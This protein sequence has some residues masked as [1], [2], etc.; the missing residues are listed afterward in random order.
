MRLLL[1]VALVASTL[2]LLTADK[3]DARI[4]GLPGIHE[5]EPVK[6]LVRKT[7]E[8]VGRGK[9][10]VAEKRQ[11]QCSAVKVEEYKNKKE[12]GKVFGCKILNGTEK[13][14]GGTTKV[15]KKGYE[16][17]YGDQDQHKRNILN[18]EPVIGF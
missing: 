9:Q 13:A 14:L 6:L 3:A 17:M 1:A 2:L 8:A 10:K 7:I 12:D 15:L 5:T 4:Q 18:Q 11:E 16:L